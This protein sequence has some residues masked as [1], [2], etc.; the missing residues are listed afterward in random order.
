MTATDV[1]HQDQPAVFVL[2]VCNID[3]EALDVE[4]FMY[5]IFK[6]CRMFR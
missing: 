4:V 6:V 5:H 1:Y 3:I 2:R